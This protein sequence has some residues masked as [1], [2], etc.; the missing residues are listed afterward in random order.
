MNIQEVEQKTGLE[1]GNIRFYEKEG[2]LHPARQSNG[3][4]DYSQEDIQTLLRIKLLRQLN[5][6]LGEIG[7]MQQQPGAFAGGP[8]PK[9]GGHSSGG[10]FLGAGGRDLPCHPGYRRGI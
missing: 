2:L 10:G 7:Q 8:Q 4:R 6:S 1:R 9:T 5:I 3:Y